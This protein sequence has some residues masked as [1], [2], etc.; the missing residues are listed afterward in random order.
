MVVICIPFHVHRSCCPV[1]EGAVIFCPPTRVAENSC[2]LQERY[3]LLAVL[4]GL[5]FAVSLA[6]IR[7]QIEGFAPKRGLYLGLRRARRHPEE[8]IEI[9][10]SA[11]EKAG[12]RKAPARPSP[13]T[14]GRR[15]CM[16]P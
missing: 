1:L 9:A 15:L 11:T 16:P 3:K 12:R 6:D 4:I 10:A 8:L 5:L 2:T 7:V 14:D 13:A